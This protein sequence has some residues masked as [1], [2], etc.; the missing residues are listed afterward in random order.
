MAHMEACAG[1]V[2][3]LHQSIELGLVT[4]VGGGEDLALLPLILPLLFNFRELILI[5]L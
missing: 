1:G 3:E 5:Q 4:V 2:R